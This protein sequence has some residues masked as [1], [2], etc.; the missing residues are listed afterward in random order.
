MGSTRLPGK[1]LADIGGT[2]MVVHTLRAAE[3]HPAIDRVCV[4][5]DH[6][7]IANVVR[8]HGGEAILTNADHTTGTDRCLEVWEKWGDDGAVLN[9][10]GDEPFPESAPIAAI[11]SGLQKAQTDVVT[12]VR[13]STNQEHLL[14]ERVKVATN[15]HHRALY[16]SRSAIPHGGP[17]FVHLGIYGF[18]PGML[19]TCA[20]LPVGRLENIEKLEQLRWLEA[21]IQIEVAQVNAAHGPGPVDTEQD[22]ARVRLWYD[23]V[24]KST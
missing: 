18:S 20:Q 15:Q 14:S 17:Y 9:L 16:F 13:P 10:Q 23:N 5:T 11:C 21:G 4:A 19:Q 3:H 6:A 12:A 24:S 1:P 2:P 7:D 8:Q 22:L